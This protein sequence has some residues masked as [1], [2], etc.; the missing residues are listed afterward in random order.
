[1]RDEY[2]KLV[3]SES[4]RKKSAKTNQVKRPV[5]KNKSAYFTVAVHKLKKGNVNIIINVK[6]VNV[7]R[8]SAKNHHGMCT[9]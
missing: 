1:M 6:L 2:T 4:A 5:V 7:L 3:S 8:P 9:I